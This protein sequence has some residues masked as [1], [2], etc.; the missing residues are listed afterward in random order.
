MGTEPD[1]TEDRPSNPMAGL[2]DSWEETREDRTRLERLIEVVTTLHE[3]TRVSSVA[4][5]ADCSANFAGD[6]LE[7][8]AGLGIV[9]KVSD[10]PA[11]YRRDE[12]H[13]RRLRT[14]N[15][16]AEYDGDVES[17]IK[18]Y[19]N[20]DKEFRDRFG[21]D[22]PAAVTWEHLDET[23]DPDELAETKRAISTWV[24][25]RHRLTDLQ[26][27]ATVDVADSESSDPFDTFA[28]LDEFA[29][30]PVETGF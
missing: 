19:R 12:I 2:S 23:D 8:L 1:A 5:K 6:K 27:A 22:S 11:E 29:D 28:D 14:R 25:V 17:A 13:F 4:K 15:L 18:D 10:N 9:E 26:R 21:V 20:R 30:E 24:V 3:P 16:V 7:L